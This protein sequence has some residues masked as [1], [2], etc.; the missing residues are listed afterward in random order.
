MLNGDFNICGIVGYIA[1]RR[2]GF[3]MNEVKAV[4]D[5]LYINALRGNDSTGVFY[6]NN[7]SEVQI[8]KEVGDSS[9]FLK[10]KEWDSTEKEL[11]R[12]GQAIV[13]H[14]RASTRGAKTDANAHP[15]NVDNKIVLVH[16]GTY[17]GSHDTLAKT[18]VDSHAIA[19]V[20]AE[21]TDIAESLRRVNAAYALV[22][23]NTETKMLY[24]VRNDKRPLFFAQLEDGSM[25][26]AS[27]IGFLYTAAWRNDLK[28]HKDYPIQLPE[29]QL[30]SCKLDDISVPYEWTDINCTYTPPP[31]VVKE[32]LKL[33]EGKSLTLV[34]TDNTKRF[35]NG[36]P[37]LV[38]IALELG[39]GQYTVTDYGKPE[40]ANQ[41]APGAKLLVE[42]TDYRVIDETAGVYYIYGKIISSNTTLNGMIAGWEIT[43]SCEYDVMAYVMDG[44]YDCI[45]EYNLCRG[46]LKPGS[47]MTSVWKMKEAVPAAMATVEDMEAQSNYAG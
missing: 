37:S 33:A 32:V 5:M 38:E 23:Y 1:N 18:E 19:H 7:Q 27:E 20:L 14:C 12:K 4:K 42:T 15:F 35:Y 17:N 45:V 9:S 10:T 34:P 13:G 44:F 6:V 46:Q 26:F 2:N 11:F 47:I 40:V 16:N 41:A 28:I 30:F 24:A 39:I 3:N 29:N 25:M 31:V 36:V 22:W 8:H 43:A 21:G